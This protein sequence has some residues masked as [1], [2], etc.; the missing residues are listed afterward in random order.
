MHAA[1]AAAGLVVVIMPLT[2]TGNGAIMPRA[3]K[4]CTE[5]ELQPPSHLPPTL[6]G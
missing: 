2:G 6:V 1:G 4:T 5:P 3:G